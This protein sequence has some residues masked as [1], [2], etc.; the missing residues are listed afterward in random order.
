MARIPTHGEFGA[1][2]GAGAKR[3]CTARLGVELREDG[4]GWVVLR[5]VRDLDG[6][7]LRGVNGYGI[8]CLG[9][10]VAPA[11]QDLSDVVGAGYELHGI[12]AAVRAGGERCLA[13]QVREGIP[14]AGIDAILCTG[15]VVAGIVCGKGAVRAGLAKRRLAEPG[16][17]GTILHASLTVGDDK[18][19]ILRRIRVVGMGLAV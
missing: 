11:G 5:I 19:G 13:V 3:V 4:E 1:L 14:L 6:C 15:E 10:G 12:R 9:N 18:R 7:G 16:E 2:E 17:H 8:G